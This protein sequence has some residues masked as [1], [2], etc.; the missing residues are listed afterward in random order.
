MDSSFIF[1]V[2]LSCQVCVAEVYFVDSLCGS[3]FCFEWVNSQGH[4]KRQTSQLHL[5]PTL[6]RQPLWS[7]QKTPRTI[8]KGL[9]SPLRAIYVPRWRSS[10]PKPR[11][12][13]RQSGCIARQWSWRFWVKLFPWN[14]P[15]ELWKAF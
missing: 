9:R 3:M 4:N 11:S 14:S 10:L 2:Q 8:C 6:R 5:W 15:L 13:M 1:W 7:S 12:Q